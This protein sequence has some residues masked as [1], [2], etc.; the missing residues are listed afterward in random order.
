[1]H[2]TREN[3]RHQ[4]YPNSALL[5]SGCIGV[6]DVRFVIDVVNGRRDLVG[7]LTV[8]KGRRRCS[9]DL[10]RTARGENGSRRRDTPCL[11]R[12]GSRQ[13][14]PQRSQDGE[15]Y[16]HSSQRRP[17]ECRRKDFCRLLAVTLP[18]L[19]LSQWKESLFLHVQ[20][21][22]VSFL[23]VRDRATRGENGGALEDANTPFSI[24][25]AELAS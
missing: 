4:A 12:K 2:A 24:S 9:N 20:V 8:V 14:G 1:M 13:G 19:V 11:R 18:V 22:S 10:R 7:S 15:R 21:F 17:H 6:P 23:T 5:T 3:G 16:N 25:L